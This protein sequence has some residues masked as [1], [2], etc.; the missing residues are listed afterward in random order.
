MA[1]ARR[2]AQPQRV[3]GLGASAGG[4]SALEQLVARLPPESGLAYVVLQHLAPSHSADL[5]NLL[6]AATKVTVRN[7]TGGARVEANTIYVVPPRTSVTL[8]RGV[9]SL[10]PAANGRRP[11]RPIDEL[12]QSLATALGDR[13][14]GVVL[15]GT[16]NDGTEGLRAIRAAGGL[17]L[18]QEP[19]TAQF[20]EMPRSAIAANAAKLVL[21][22]SAIGE[23]L[24]ALAGKVASLPAGDDEAPSPALLRIF[25]QLREATGI[26]FTS[27]KRA[28]IDRRLAKRL[29]M[30]R[31]DSLEE[32][33]ELLAT[34]PQERNEVHEDLLIHV[35]EFFRDPAALDELVSVLADEVRDRSKDVPV[36]VWVPG[37]STGEEVYSLAMLLVERLGP[38]RQLQLFG[39]DLS[40]RAIAAARVGRY[41]ET[42]NEQVS[43]E[44]LARFFRH[45]DGG[46]LVKQQLRESCVFARHDLVSDPPF[47]RLD[48]VSCRNLLIYLGPALQRRVI[49][50]VHYALNQPGYLLLGRSETVGDFDA[51]FSLVSGESRIYARKPGARVSLTFPGVGQQARPAWPTTAASIRSGH[52]VQRDVDHVLLARYAPPCVLVDENFDVIQFRGRTGAYLEPPPGQPQLNVVRMARS[53]LAAELPLALQLAQRT[54]A[55]VRREDVIVREGRREHRLNLEVVP[56]RG[57]TEDKRHYLI[58]FEPAP[59]APV[60]AR[61]KK[62]APPPKDVAEVQ[63]LRHE[64]AVTKE[65]LMAVVTQNLATS[66]ELGLINEEL[67]STNEELQSS[68]EEIQTAKE[69]MQSTN[70][71]LET[72]NEELHRG[73]DQLREAN[74]DLVNVLASVE[75]AMIIVD[76]ERCVRRFT[77]RARMVMKLLATDL[78]RPIADLQPSI[79]VDDLDATIARVIETLEMTESEVASAD[80]SVHYRMQV[81]PYRTLDQTIGGAVLTFVDITALRSAREFRTAI[82]ETVPTPLLVL[83]DGLVIQ[84]VNRAGAEL[85]RSTEEELAGRSL[86]EVGKWQTDDLRTQLEAAVARGAGFTDLRAEFDVDGEDFAL[87]VSANSIVQP[88]TPRSIL[89]GIADNTKLEAAHRERDAFLDA[90]SHELRTPLSAILL[91]A[92]ALR[93]LDQADPQRAKAIETIIE[94]VRA[95]AGLVDD[96]LEIALSRT[97][98]LAVV[99]EAANPSE[100]VTDVVTAAR[101]VARSKQITLDLEAS[102]G[103]RIALDPRRLEQIVSKLISNALK[104]TPSGGRVSVSVAYPDSSVELRVADTGPGIPADRLSNL[105]EPFVK[106]DGST[107]R[108]HAGLG[109]GLPLVRHLVERHGGTINVDSPGVG[110]GT[111]VT[112]QIP[113]R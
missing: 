13:A 83:D 104:F 109:I 46:Y 18:V 55:L 58:V 23:H 95:E 53:G 87:R 99:L 5:A 17:T 30:H 80:G 57:P 68:N 75:I 6:A 66:E 19:S 12:F 33:S 38:N 96:L 71:E 14:V 22:P 50:I 7:L 21:A 29:A 45:E 1:K 108:A 25:G 15:S 36:R 72:L 41:P 43:Q 111:S 20:D 51:L 26:D 97:T 28:T 94:S 113:A 52:D 60:T 65:N 106:R 32:Y 31:L 9:L 79:V 77:P 48:L 69:E 37:C 47:S 82:V 88:G 93:T 92:Q 10:K 74:D 4:L 40:E 105:F 85:F 67:Q 98:E 49:P 89:V 90:V 64:L 107:S 24:A 59:D 70:E 3:V 11:R 35:T 84:S 27:Y 34:D 76:T 91:W 78:G 73:N 2:P 86:F 39:T 56:V 101:H 42:I 63:R 100:I 110:H 112:V 102:P 54:N 61:R 16:A 81:R 44:R 8:S 103:K 62:G